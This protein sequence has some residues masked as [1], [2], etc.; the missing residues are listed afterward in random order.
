[1]KVF[2]LIK[3]VKKIVNWRELRIMITFCPVCSCK[4]VM[5]KFDSNAIAVRC[6]SCRASAV[7]MSIVSIL[8]EVAPEIS[9]LDAYE[10][11]SRGPLFRYLITKAKTVTS[12]EY[13]PDVAS[14]GFK[15]GIQIQD[16]QNLSYADK[17]F[18]ICTSTEVFEHVPDDTKGFSEILRVLR[19]NGIFVFTVPLQNAY[20]TIERTIL[21]AN[22][23][24][25]HLLPPEYHDDPIGESGKILAFRTYGQDIIEK[26]LNAG[27]TKAEIVIP[28]KQIPWG[29]ARQVVVAH[30]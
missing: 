10:L 12:S 16:V 9:S 24:I 23:E 5:I 28:E 13:C 30:R 4:R 19:P 2:E 17:S 15:N 1:M 27:F 22:G 6:L 11:S 18:D 8:R 14:G 25:Q 20:K 26:L 29:F 7:Y 21:T 3:K